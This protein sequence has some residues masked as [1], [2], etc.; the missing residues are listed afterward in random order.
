MAYVNNY[1]QLQVLMLNQMFTK[2]FISSDSIV[3]PN[4]YDIYDEEGRY[5]IRDAQ[6]EIHEQLENFR[7]SPQFN[8]LKAQYESLLNKLNDWCAEH[9]C[10]IM[11]DDETINIEQVTPAFEI[12]R[13][14]LFDR[15]NYFGAHEAIFFSEGKQALEELWLLLQD[16]LIPLDEKKNALME[17]QR[18]V[19][20]CADGI[21][22]HIR[23]AQNAVKAY[24]GIKNT[25]Q[26]IK[27][28]FIRQHSTPYIQSL[29]SDSGNYEGFEIHYANAFYN[30]VAKDFGLLEQDDTYIDDLEKEII[31]E[32]IW[33]Y[34]KMLQ[35]QAT[36]SRMLEILWLKL[37]TDLSWMYSELSDEMKSLS[38]NAQDFSQEGN[39]T[40]LFQQESMLISQ[41]LE[42]WNAKYG[43][44]I[45]LSFYDL[46][47]L[48][49]KNIIVLLEL[50]AV[51]KAL[52]PKIMRN[53]SEHYLTPTQRFTLKINSQLTVHFHHGLLWCEDNQLLRT[54]T[55][56]DF[57]KINI[58]NLN[59][60]D[61]VH[62]CFVI[63]Q[64]CVLFPENTK[65]LLAS[66]DDE[67]LK[68][69]WN[70]GLINCILNLED[71]YPR[72]FLDP[73]Q[74]NK[75]G[76][77]DLIIR[78]PRKI[79]H[80]IANKD[81]YE[82]KM[83]IFDVICD[84]E[85]VGKTTLLGYAAHAQMWNY[86]FNLLDNCYLTREQFLA[87]I[88][89][90]QHDNVNIVWTLV[91]E[92]QWGLIESLI[93]DGLIHSSHFSSCP[94]NEES[95][96]KEYNVLDLLA[97]G[98]Q[99]DFIENLLEKDVIT[100]ELLVPIRQ[101]AI[102]GQKFWRALFRNQKWELIS[103]VVEKKLVTTAMLTPVNED[104]RVLEE[105]SANSQWSILEKL[106]NQEGL[107]TEELLLKSKSAYLL[108]NFAEAKQVGL[109]N[110]L[111]QKKLITPAVIK[112]IT[113]NDENIF[114][115]LARTQQWEILRKFFDIK[116]LITPEIFNLQV[117]TFI[118][119]SR[120][121]ISNR[122]EFALWV[123][124]V[125]EKSL[126]EIN[127]LWFL[128]KYKQ[129]DLIDFLLQKELITSSMLSSMPEVTIASENFF[130]GEN[131]LYLLGKN[132]QWELLEKFAKKDLITAELLHPKI[133]LQ[134]TPIPSLLS[135]LL[136]YE[137]WH[138]IIIL[139]EK[140]LI[141]S[142][143]LENIRKINSSNDF[144]VLDLLVNDL[145][146]LNQ[147][148]SEDLSSSFKKKKITF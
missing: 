114:H 10:R 133:L 111:L 28:E 120:V 85:N 76:L 106:F 103:L 15:N 48:D 98:K 112:P 32:H 42:Q 108:F 57:S 84:F 24:K 8:L 62:Y 78:Y 55:L 5:F 91:A 43:A 65:S 88:S 131:V 47:A 141:N 9:E 110:I 115:L 93:S 145:Y 124:M 53:F 139:L 104:R 11:L 12:L 82:T 34:Q 128:A 23:Q 30:L 138:L 18:N 38:A 29:Y 31:P 40:F 129:W 46:A 1:Y 45:T 70:N 81:D 7:Q 107:I 54:I 142:N 3:M 125:L 92:Q 79:L 66:L 123:Q 22:T 20:V 37:R 105:L 64:L 96:Y 102:N 56:D 116:E 101:E 137:R 16:E 51:I 17:L 36:P 4:V 134:D 69:I 140:Q 135:L 87:T 73:T 122:K 68:I 21:V 130:Q 146:N 13:N 148:D 126:Q 143:L 132:C 99:W 127:L 52:E 59:D 109:I 119:P 39:N 14:N 147:Q 89:Y 113:I 117:S 26:A 95:R 27:T 72:S 25:L 90:N 6:I 74:E 136:D 44:L 67:L 2:S 61:K 35:E 77:K 58:E 33:H 118:L 49:D 121:N 41:V 94:L 19:D 60:H 144:M 71:M 75:A 97:R 63:E 80:Y 100:A 86:I 50:P 83:A